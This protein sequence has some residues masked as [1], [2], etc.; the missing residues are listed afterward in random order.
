MLHALNLLIHAH[1]RFVAHHGP[2]HADTVSET[3][4]VRRA[5]ESNVGIVDLQRPGNQRRGRPFAVG[6]GDQDDM[7]EPVLRIAQC[8]QERLRGLEPE[9]DAVGRAREQVLENLGI[10]HALTRSAP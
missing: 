6:A 4:Q 7:L 8:L 5:E 10:R 3:E 2:T 1:N 9:L